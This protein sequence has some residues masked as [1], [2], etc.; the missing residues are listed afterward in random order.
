VL[1][2]LTAFAADLL[3]G[4]APGRQLP[5]AEADSTATVGRTR[6]GLRISAWR[7]FMPRPGPDR[8]GSDLMVNLQVQSLDTLPLPTDLAVDSAWVRSSGELWA[9]APSREPRPDL[10]NGLDLMLRGGPRWPTHRRVD[11]LV[12]VQGPGGVE[13][14]L[15]L[16]RQPIGRT[17]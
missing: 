9:T 1:F 15:G 10:A 14:Y 2:A 7:D 6:I 4:Q 13:L 17:D 16:R 3:P 12:R 11:L 5:W 8:G